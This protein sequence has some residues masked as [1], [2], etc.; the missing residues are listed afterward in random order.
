MKVAQWTIDA[1]AD[2]AHLDELYAETAPDYAD[3]VGDATVL[4]ANFLAERPYAGPPIG[5]GHERKWNVRTTH[6]I[7]IY[8]IVDGG[9]EVLRVRHGHENW[10]EN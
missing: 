1:Q 4:A 10:Q 6:Y 3:R 8:R 2:L 9:V 5:E 7:L